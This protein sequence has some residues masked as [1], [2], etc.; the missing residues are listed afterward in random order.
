MRNI[1]LIF[2]SLCLVSAPALGQTEAPAW[3]DEP[4]LLE[5]SAPA[6]AETEYEYY[7]EEPAAEPAPAVEEEYV[8]AA[9][10]EEVVEEVAA[11]EPTTQEAKE[12]HVTRAQET[13]TWLGMGLAGGCVTVDSEWSRDLSDNMRLALGAGWGL[14]DFYTVTKLTAGVNYLINEI[15]VEYISGIVELYGGGKLS[16]ANYSIDVQDLILVGT[17]KSGGTYGINATLGAR[18]DTMRIEAALDTALGLILIF[19]NRFILH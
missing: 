6:D 11:E 5:E 19:E 13:A 17:G 18:Y 15:P 4:D 12:E 16:Y 8:P 10:A 3:L 1:L 7:Y 9:E 14:G 2:I